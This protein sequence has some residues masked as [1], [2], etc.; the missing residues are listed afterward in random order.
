MLPSPETYT[1]NL[2]LEQQVA[3]L[4]EEEVSAVL[5]GLDLSTLPWDWRWSARPQQYLDPADESWSVL[6]AMA[7]RGA[8]KTKLSTEW[9]REMDQRW[10]NMPERY[11]MTGDGTLRIALLSRTAADVRDTLITGPSGLLHIYPPSLQ[12]KVEWVP[13]LRR[14]TLPNGAVATTFSAEE[15]DQLR[16][17]EFHIGLADELAA[18]RGKPGADGLVAWENLRIACRMGRTPQVVGATTPKRVPLMRKLLKEARDNPKIHV[19][20][21]KTFD[22]PYLSNSYLDLMDSLYGGTSIGA[23]ELD[24]EMLDDVVGALLKPFHIDKTRITSLPDSF[25]GD[26]W[27]RILGVDPSVS[28]T[29]GDECGIVLAGAPKLAQHHQRHAF[30]AADETLVASPAVWARRVAVLA[31]EHKAMVAVE[32]NQGGALTQLAV[33]QAAKEMGLPVPRIQQMWATGSKKVRAEPIGIAY[34]RGRIHHLNVFPEME[35]QLTEWVE[36]ESGYSPDRM[37]ALVWATTPLLIPAVVKSGSGGAGKIQ[38][39]NRI[40]PGLGLT[41]T[42]TR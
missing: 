18:H 20:K 6:L 19:R 29:P 16:G 35:S 41:R 8:G 37:D 9:V 4:S 21:M 34:E 40:R 10:E 3:M 38:S 36:G 23:Q 27:I 1:G 30:V 14:L 13:S 31:D 5:D 42:G 2:S 15:P 7:G 25:Y 24:G 17:P 33:T 32:S 22:N 11:G 28:D 12:D 39:V 26:N